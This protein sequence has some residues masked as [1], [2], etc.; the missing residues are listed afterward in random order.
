MTEKTLHRI[1]QTRCRLVRFAIIVLAGFIAYCPGV[2]AQS[3]SS[4]AA[5]VRAGATA[6]QDGNYAA[7]TK[8]LNSA[9]TSD[10]LSQD[11][12][13][14]ALFFRGIAN[15][16][17]GR[18]GAAVSD[19]NGALWLKGLTTNQ[20]AQ[21]KLYLGLAYRSAG[22]ADKAKKELAEAKKLAPNDEQI[23][24]AI[25]GKKVTLGRS[26][27]SSIR[28]F[29]GRNKDE[30]PEPVSQQAAAPAA[31]PSPAAPSSA[32]EAKKAEPQQAEIP[33]FRT[34]I[35][36][37]ETLAAP[38]QR[39]QVA[40]KEPAAATPWTTS[41]APEPEAAREAASDEAEGSGEKEKG[42]FGRF[43]SSILPSSDDDE[44]NAVVA[45]APAPVQT[46]WSKS[47]RVEE[48]KEPAAANSGL[49]KSYRVQLASS[50]SEKEARD[51]WAQLASQYGSELGGREPVIE[52]TDLGTLG[53]FYRL[54][55]GPFAEKQEPLRLC[56]EFKRNGLD[57]FLVSR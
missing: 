47:T 33:A 51:Y 36:P 38:P 16:Q 23:A 39:Q 56:N 15:R 25:A 41:V 24:S 32:T 22:L 55:V 6:V 27:L 43:F 17:L 53:T 45:A 50:R 11:E 18:Q 37:A 34:T 14:K 29:F 57:C 35:T 31:P 2:L 49:G 42:R 5:L 3:N 52:K 12:M 20:R 21:A 8:Q 13:S 44:P 7:A 46:D 54:Q 1:R 48:F 9:I 26:S 40:K 10:K 19:F 4:G 30:K 28:S